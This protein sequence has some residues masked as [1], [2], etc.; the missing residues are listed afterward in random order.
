MAGV[1]TQ[2]LEVFRTVARY[3][4]VTAAAR[5]MGFTQSAVSRQIAALETEVGVRVFDRLPRGVAITEEGRTLL[6][7]AEAVLNRLTTPCSDSVEPLEEVGQQRSARVTCR[8][9][10]GVPLSADTALEHRPR[11]GRVH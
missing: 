3:G 1:E 5:H 11:D 7:H 4:S 9:R 2:L 6:P 8:P 10:H